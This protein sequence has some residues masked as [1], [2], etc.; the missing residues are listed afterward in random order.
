MEAKVIQKFFP[1]LISA[2]AACV[3]NVSDHYFS[4]SLIEDTTHRKV[5]ESA[6]TEKDRTRILICTV[7]DTI[8]RNPECFNV[9]MN[10]LEKVLPSV[11]D[12]LLKAMK[13]EVTSSLSE[14]E[15]LSPPKFQN[16]CG[17][18]DSD[19]SQL[20]QPTS[21]PSSKGDFIHHN[22]AVKGPEESDSMITV[23]VISEGATCIS[24]TPTTALESSESSHS[25]I[26]DAMTT[27]ESADD[28]ICT[29]VLNQ[30]CTLHSQGEEAVE[31]TIFSRMTQ[32][33]INSDNGNESSATQVQGEYR[34][35]PS[36]VCCMQLLYQCLSDMYMEA[37]TDNPP[38]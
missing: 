23:S 19:T 26:A 3:Q 11:D 29:L 1:R 25:Q 13:A 28:H 15:H 17:S 2:V 4:E 18:S 34:V 33:S 9:F 6:D 8:A 36:E 32:T 30:S 38:Q 20:Q 37:E 22:Q 31:G 21:E 24:D 27:S 14:V 5:L 16:A 7:R 35:E 12:S 10:V